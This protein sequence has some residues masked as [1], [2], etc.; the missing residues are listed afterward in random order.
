MKNY[1]KHPQIKQFIILDILLKRPFFYIINPDQFLFH[2][3]ILWPPT[4]FS[5]QKRVALQET[6]TKQE[7]TGYNKTRQNPLYQ[8]WSGQPVGGK[9]SQEQVKNSETR[10]LLAVSKTHQ[11]NIHNLYAEDLCAEPML[12][13][14]VSLS[15]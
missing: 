8:S 2:S 4:P 12:S 5:L 13:A 10:L 14:L 11:A 1:L 15:L 7:K 9:N 3:L 6:T